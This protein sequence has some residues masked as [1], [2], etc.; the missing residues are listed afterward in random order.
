MAQHPEP[1]AQQRA[2]HA[3]RRHSRTISG[4]ASR[5]YLLRVERRL[6]EL[7]GDEDRTSGAFPGSSRPISLFG[8]F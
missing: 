2:V 7:D 4:T 8:A 1:S 6:L 3:V 5:E